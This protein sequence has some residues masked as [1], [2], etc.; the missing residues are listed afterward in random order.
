M[1]VAEPERRAVFVDSSAYGALANPRD[2]DHRQAVALARHLTEER[3][4]FYTTNFVVA[5]THALVLSRAGRDVAYRLL[6]QLDASKQIVV[7]V[8]E[9]D[10]QN[11]R[12]VIASYRD[13][14][15]SLVDALSFVVMER[16]HILTAFTFDRHFQ[17]YGF[18]VVEAR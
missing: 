14:D 1:R 17:Q 4:R 6:T 11:A 18:A 5:E 12:R 16:L 8:G 13:K 15:F 7:R 3:L 2:Q 9:D 10:E